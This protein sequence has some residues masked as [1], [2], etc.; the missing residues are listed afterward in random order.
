MGAFLRKYRGVLI[1]LLVVIIAVSAY[2]FRRG[3]VVRR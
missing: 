3:T 2:A 1:F